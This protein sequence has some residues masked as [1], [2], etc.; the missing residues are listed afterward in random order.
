MIKKRVYEKPFTEV[1]NVETENLLAAFSSVVPN[2]GSTD[3][4]VEIIEGDPDPSHEEWL[5]EGL[6][7]QQNLW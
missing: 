6:K 4:N 2:E 7:N 5:P 3:P 1:V